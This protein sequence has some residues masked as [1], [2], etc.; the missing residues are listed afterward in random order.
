MVGVQNAYV[1]SLLASVSERTVPEPTRT[2]LLMALLGIA[3]LGVLLI[4][5][6]LLGGHWVRKLGR[7][8]RGPAVPRDVIIP[9]KNPQESDESNSGNTILIHESDTIISG[10]DQTSSESRGSQ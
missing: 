3:L 8:R 5:T 10:N 9:R 7:F 4:L 2:I 6:T 1:S